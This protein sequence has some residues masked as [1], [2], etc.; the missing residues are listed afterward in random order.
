[1]EVE[2]VGPSLRS[3]YLEEEEV[4]VVS[5]LDVEEEVWEG[6]ASAEGA[7][8]SVWAAVEGGGLESVAPEVVEVV[9][10]RSGRVV[11]VPEEGVAMLLSPL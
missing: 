4:L 9:T 3:G 2:D 8:G 5:C 11:V 1:M 7:M 6:R 10:E